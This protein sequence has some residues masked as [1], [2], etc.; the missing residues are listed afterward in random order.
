MTAV[1]LSARDLRIGFGGI[2]AAD[3]VDL[4]VLTGERLAIIGPNGAGKTTFINLCT[5]YLR[6]LS[7]RVTFDG[8]EIVG[9]TPREITRLVVLE[10]VRDAEAVEEWLGEQ[11]RPR[12]RADQRERWEVERD[13]SRPRPAYCGTA[14]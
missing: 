5:G 11:A 10:A 14:G 6:P 12:C 8:H 2:R 7:G 4:D 1:L 3:G 9:R 13:G